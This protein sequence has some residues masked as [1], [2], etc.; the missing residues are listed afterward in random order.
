MLY[1][2]P[3]VS[4]RAN[5]V[6]IGI[7]LNPNNACNWHCL[8]CQVP[9]LK[10]GGPPPVD[11]H[12]LENELAQML[13]HIVNGG[14]METRVPESQ[15]RLIDLAFSG[16]GEP[17]NAAEFPEAVGLAID[18]LKRYRL[19]HQL[20][21]RLITNGSFL[22]RPAVREGIAHIGRIS[23]EVWFKVDSVN[24]DTTKRINGA[25]STLAITERR[26]LACSQLCPTWVQTCLFVNDG[27]PPSQTEIGDLADF[28]GSLRHAL[29][30][31]HLYGLARPSAQKGAEKLSALPVSDL[32]KIAAILR[33]KGLT[34]T[35][36][37]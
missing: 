17:T 16:N 33:Q 21:L 32:E 25:R 23:G 31:I 5:G 29:A 22:D 6:S 27:Q 15:R 1:V 37:P 30:G 11:L 26:L 10:R 20:K 8:Y 7:N 36:S 3:V 2:Y 13:D 28:L 14:F 12:R 4:R 34:V 24:P 18:L 19:E 35:V 9:E